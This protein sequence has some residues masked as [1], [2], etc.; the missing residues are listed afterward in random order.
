MTIFFPANHF[1]YINES[2]HSNIVNFVILIRILLKFRFFETV[3]IH[4]IEELLTITA[5]ESRIENF[6]RFERS[7]QWE[8]LLNSPI[9]FLFRES[10]SQIS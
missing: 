9:S 5:S 7:T 1:N 10:V 6:Q 8:D 2:L 4:G 3:T